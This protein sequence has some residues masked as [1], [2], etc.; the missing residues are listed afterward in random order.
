M[1]FIE[2]LKLSR[3]LQV[4]AILVFDTAWRI[5]TGKEGIT[6]SDLGVL[7]DPVGKPVL[8][9]SSLKGKLRSTC[10]S[11]AHAMNLS[12]CFLNATASGVNC[13]SDINYFSDVKEQHNHAIRDGG[14]EK[15][16]AWI[17][18]HTC[19]V[20]KL[21][22]SPVRAARLRCADGQL[23]THD[24]AVVQ[25]R[26]GVVLDRDSHTAVPGL[27]YDY[28]V[29]PART[30]FSLRFD[31]D[32]ATDADEA[33]FGAALFEWS[34]GSSIGGFTSRGLGRFHLENIKVLGVNLEDAK[35][36]VAYLTTTDPSKRLRDR[37]DW[38][39]YFTD[40]I[41]SASGGA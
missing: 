40:K 6:S 31:L 13:V 23:K 15:L 24:A 14:P 27:K 25:V 21:F 5:G 10:E 2:E 38:Q 28:E 12:A 9:G 39:A 34:T 37:G 26:D 11:L 30:S 18:E 4:T 29:L 35:E 8:P 1:S 22:G 33:L 32:N 3:R 20:C 36:R 16:L 41:K 17:N 19:D 7:L